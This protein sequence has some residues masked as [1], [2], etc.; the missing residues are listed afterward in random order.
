MLLSVGDFTLWTLSGGLEVV[1]GDGFAPSRPLPLFVLPRLDGYSID[2]LPNGYVDL[3]SLV[4][5]W[6]LAIDQFRRPPLLVIVFDFL[7]FL[8]AF[9]SL[10]PL[11]P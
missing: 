5:G 2:T 10:S 6:F 3:S 1:V 7:C 11:V 8:L 4:L 9:F